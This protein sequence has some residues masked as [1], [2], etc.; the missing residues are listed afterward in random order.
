MVSALVVASASLMALALPAS[1]ASASTSCPVAPV[2]VNGGFEIPSTGVAN[3][4]LPAANAGTP[5]PGIG[6]STND[7]SLVLEIWQN[8]FLG[9]PTDSGAQFVEINANS[10]DTLTQNVATVPG[11][12]IRWHLAHRGRLGTD[13]MQLQVGAP[14]GPLTAQVP[15]GQSVPDISDGTTA[16]GHY[17]GVYTVPAGQTT[18]RMDFASISQTGPASYGNFLDSVSLELLPTA[19]D[20]T[21]STTPGHSVTIPVLANDCG[22]TLSVHAVGAVSH[23]TAVIAGSAITYKPSATFVGT[24][25]FAYTITDA[26]GDLATAFVTVHVSAPTGPTA[27][28][29]VSNGDPGAVQVVRPHL[30]AGSVLRLL[31]AH[32]HATT[33]LSVP[34]QGV[35]AVA[36]ATLTF[37]PDSAFTGTA[38]VVRYEIVDAFGQTAISTYT[39]TVLVPLTAGGLPDTGA[40][41]AGPLMAGLGLVACGLVLMIAGRASRRHA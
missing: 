15:D 9:V 36:G 22:S 2:L 8:G 32:G 19:N 6:W 28:P 11:T 41:Y 20:D 14:A 34:G 29:Q 27:L 12:K 38:D 7:P 13:T 16:W 31:D 26:S 30:P 4:D 3:T 23:G 17:T 24:E 5:T 40:N 35:F 21:A 39:A 1:P 33:A 18:T 10:Q 25:H 37:T